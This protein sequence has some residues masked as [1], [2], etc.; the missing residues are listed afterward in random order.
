MSFKKK[1][2]DR[3]RDMGPARN[4]FIKAGRVRV[5][6]EEGMIGEMPLSEALSLAEEKSLDLVQVSNQEVP[7]CRLIDYGKFA[8]DQSKKQKEKNKHKPKETKTVKLSYVMGVGDIETRL[9][10][11]LQFLESECQVKI[12]MRLAGRQNMFKDLA[13]EKFEE[14]INKVKS[15]IEVKFVSPVKAS[16]GRGVTITTVIDNNK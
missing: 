10:R 16:E 3:R 15:S 2:V 1:R 7:I 14:F 13:L 8:Y 11:T 4:N 6:S 12:E 9:K 5:V